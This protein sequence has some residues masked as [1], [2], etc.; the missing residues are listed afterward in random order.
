MSLLLFLHLKKKQENKRGLLFVARLLCGKNTH[1]DI[2]KSNSFSSVFSQVLIGVH[3]PGKRVKQTREAGG[4]RRVLPRRWVMIGGRC[5][6]TIHVPSAS[7]DKRLASQR[8]RGNGGM[9]EGG[10]HG[11]VKNPNSVPDLIPAAE[12]AQQTW[13]SSLN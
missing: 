4:T 7:A 10:C 6:F 12:T 9:E 11:Q 3:A 2:I 1:A 5:P 8:H 13:L